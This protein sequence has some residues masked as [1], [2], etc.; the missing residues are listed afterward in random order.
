VLLLGF[1]V[2]PLLAAFVSDL[3][4]YWFHRAQHALGL[5]WRFHAVHHSIE[6]LNCFNE[7]HHVSEA[8]TR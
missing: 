5:L 8:A 3:F 2:I 7:W 4:Y 1:T 6:E